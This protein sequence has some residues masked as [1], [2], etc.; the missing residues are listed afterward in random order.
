MCMFSKV[1]DCRFYGC[2]GRATVSEWPRSGCMLRGGGCAGSGVLE[3]SC[4]LSWSDLP[5]PTSSFLEV[6]SSKCSLN[7]LSAYL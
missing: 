1:M 7:H 4:N 6:V 2:W 5:F 3:T